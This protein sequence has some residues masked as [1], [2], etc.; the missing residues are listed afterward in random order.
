MSVRATTIAEARLHCGPAAS[1]HLHRTAPLVHVEPGALAVRATSCGLLCK[2]LNVERLLATA[3][4]L[5]VTKAPV[6]YQ[7]RPHLQVYTG[8]KRHDERRFSSTVV[9]GGYH[10]CRPVNRHPHLTGRHLALRANK[11]K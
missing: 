1:K 9:I 3:S 10:P 2:I 6:L 7:T 4:C 5:I 11:G 8:Q